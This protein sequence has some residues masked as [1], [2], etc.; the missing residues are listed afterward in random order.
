MGEERVISGDYLSN[1]PNA[2]QFPD[3]GSRASKETPPKSAVVR[4]FDGT[5]D[6]FDSVGKIIGAILALVL[7]IGGIVTLVNQCSPPPPPPQNA[8]LDVLDDPPPRERSLRYYL[9]DSGQ[10]ERLA[11]YTQAELK[12]RGNYYAVRITVDGLRGRESQIVWSLDRRDKGTP[13]EDLADSDQW[14]HQFLQAVKPPANSYTFTAKVW[15]QRP[16]YPGNFY[17]ILE[18]DYPEDQSLAV[19]AT[20][21]FVV[22]EP[23]PKTEVRYVTTTMVTMIPATTVSVTTV[24][25]PTITATTTTTTTGTTPTTTTTGTTTTT[26]TTTSAITTTTTETI[27]ETTTSRV[28]TVPHV[29]TIPRKPPAQQ[30]KPRPPAAIEA[31]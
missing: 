25:T 24:I 11:D 7:L 13:I 8:D 29:I 10:S 5:V 19:T 3:T 31:P 1:A 9:N 27:P 23:P 12:Q 26:T 14:I 30:P 15:I 4:W 22:T 2:Q 18:I 6:W 20:P 16:P 17:A 21:A 28:V